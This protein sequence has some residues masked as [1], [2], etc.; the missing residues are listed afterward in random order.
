MEKVAVVPPGAPPGMDP[1]AMG[2]APPGGAPPGMDPAAMGGAPPP[3]DPSMMGGAPPGGAPQMAP[4]PMPGAPPMGG[5]QPPMMGD[6]AQAAAMG[7]PAPKLKPEQMMQMLDFRLYN[8]QMQMTAMMNALN[9]QLPPGALVTPPGS[10]TP[11][12][13]SAVPG[14]PQDP[15]MAAGGAGGGDQGGGGAGGS[16]ISPIDAIQGASPGLAGGG[17]GGG[18]KTG[19][20]RMSFSDLMERLAGDNDPVAPVYQN[21]VTAW[22]DEPE[23]T[24]QKVAS[25]GVPYALMDRQSPATNAAAVAAMLRARTAGAA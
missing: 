11:V 10:P 19:Y 21:R 25:V 3:M 13:E 7:Q 1:S 20:D 17:G 23:N 22:M 15:S 9:V 18:E 4:P 16:A 6:P 8:M 24:K 14:G 2:G 12:A 5:A